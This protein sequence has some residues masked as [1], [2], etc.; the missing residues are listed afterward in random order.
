M[1]RRTRQ[2]TLHILDKDYVVACSDDDCTDLL[3]CADYFSKKMQEVREGGK[4]VGTERL[5]V[6]TALNIVHELLRYKT[7]KTGYT[8]TMTEELQR[9]Q[10]K[11]ALALEQGRRLL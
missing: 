6:M 3:A 2:V 1:K 11:L 9:L 7:Q 5:L 8:E 10:N 4:V